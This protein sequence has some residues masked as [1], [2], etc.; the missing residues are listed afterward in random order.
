MGLFGL[1]GGK[2]KDEAKPA[3]KP[4]PAAT[5]IAEP[6]KAAAPVKATP[7][8]AAMA[9]TPAMVAAVGA[10][11]VRLRLKLVAAVKTGKTAAAYQ[12][13][14]SLADIQ[15]KAGRRL[16]ARMWAQQAERILELDPK[17]A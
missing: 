4:A 16:G 5:K 6:A 9:E 1:F 8:A 11:Q 2:K 13:A 10:E 12:A 15:A 17:A 7:A 14:K 3:A